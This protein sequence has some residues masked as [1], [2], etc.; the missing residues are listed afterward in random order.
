M[1]AEKQLEQVKKQLK[2]HPDDVNLL[3]RQASL[4]QQL[5]R[6]GDALN[7]LNRI[8]EL[9]PDHYEALHR[10]ELIKSIL[11]FTNIDI[12]SDTNTDH[13]PWLE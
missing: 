9:V 13:D 6:Y 2:H 4:L 10:R 12:F 5:G 3:Y 1:R 11:K 7:I 8:L